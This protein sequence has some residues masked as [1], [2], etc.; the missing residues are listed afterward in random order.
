ME[1]GSL[2]VAQMQGSWSGMPWRQPWGRG[3]SPPSRKRPSRTL[4]GWSVL[5]RRRNR[6]LSRRN[7]WCTG[8]LMKRAST[9]SSSHPRRRGCLSPWVPRAP[10]RSGMRKPAP[11]TSGS[12]ATSARSLASPCAQQTRS[13]SHRAARITQCACGTSRMSILA[14]QTRRSAARRLLASTSP[15]SPSRATK[16]ASLNSAS[17]GT[18]SCSPAPPRTAKCGS[19]FRRSQTRSSARSSLR[20][21]L[22]SG[23]SR[24]RPTST[25][26]SVLP[27]TA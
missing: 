22:G 27:R 26:S 25:S 11:W 7:P 2:P 4:S 5:R 14:L 3:A 13:S 10:S 17:A 6:R 19:G 18:V 20:T 12:W 15:T 16:G 8:R 9:S 21:R 1:P 23:I 24:G